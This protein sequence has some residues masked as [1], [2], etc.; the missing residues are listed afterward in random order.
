[1]IPVARPLD[2]F[3]LKNTSKC[4]C[5]L[6]GALLCGATVVPA[7]AQK[8]TP[9][10]VEVVRT[11][12]LVNRLELSG[13]VTSPRVSQISTS[14]PGLIEAVHFDSGAKVEAGDLLLELDPKLEEMALKEAEAEA[15][16]AEAELAD[17]RRRLK[18]AENLEKRSFAPKNTVDT[19]K[20]ELQ[21][22]AATIARRKAQQAAA[23]ERLDRHL[24]RAPYSGVISQRMAEVGEWVVPGT[25]IFELVD[26][27][28]LRVDVP[29]PQQY[30]PQIKTGAEVTLRFD[31]LPDAVLPAKTQALIPVSDPKVRTFTLR[32]LPTRE[33]VS[34]TPGMSARVS[35][36][37]AT[38][39][40]GIVVSRDA[41]VRYPDGRITVWV[42]ESNGEANHVK[43]RRVEIGL[44]FDGL[45]QIRSG[46]K[47]GE[48]VVV[49]GNESLREGQVVRLAS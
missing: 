2:I 22:D 47:E 43:E 20:N 18:I 11:V 30:Y 24:V 28:G 44:S 39:Q 12:P 13:T 41:L 8:A 40:R 48:R 36:R 46:L 32:V 31:A 25:T 3:W 38:G 45:V 5:V 21:I 42:L 7:Y 29:V 9:V 17:A 34:I 16:Q 6:L 10:A 33:N 49:R 19:L 26:M 27:G 4:A 14:V 15:Q 1:M 37:L 35:V 23:A